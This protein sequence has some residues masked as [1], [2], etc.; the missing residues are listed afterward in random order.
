MTGAF[1]VAGTVAIQTGDV[2]LN[3]FHAEL[4]CGIGHKSLFAF[5]SLVRKALAIAASDWTHGN[6]LPI[7]IHAI[8]GVAGASAWSHTQSIDA[9]FVANGVTEVEIVGIAFVALTADFNA[10]Q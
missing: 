4:P 7:Q 3:P 8:V 1:V 2:T 6:A 5:A 10:A 9:G